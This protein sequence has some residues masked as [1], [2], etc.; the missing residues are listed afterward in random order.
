[1]EWEE[2]LKRFSMSDKMLII[3]LMKDRTPRT[4]A[5]IVKELEWDYTA[6]TVSMVTKYLNK[7]V[8]YPHAKWKFRVVA[9]IP[10]KRYSVPIKVYK[11]IGD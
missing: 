11:Y 3:N 2:V 9:E 10:R 7:Q 6:S 4:S 5:E 8:T 1:M